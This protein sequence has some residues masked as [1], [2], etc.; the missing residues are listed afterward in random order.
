LRREHTTPFRKLWT[1]VSG[2]CVLET[3]VKFPGQ[4]SDVVE[5][6]QQL[7]LQSDVIW[8]G[9]LAS[10]QYANGVDTPVVLDGV[11]CV[12]RSAALR[13]SRLG[14]FWKRAAWKWIAKPL[15]VFERRMHAQATLSVLNSEV[16]AEYMV[17][18][19]LGSPVVIENGCDTE[20]FRPDPGLESVALPGSPTI[21][22]VGVF[23]YPPNRDAAEWLVEDL[24]PRLLRHHPDARLY[25]VGPIRSTGLLSCSDSIFATG[26]V[27]DVRPYYAQADVF[28][29]PLRYGTGIKNK[30]LEA[31]A[32]ECR[33]VATSAAVEGLA[34]RHDEHLLIADSE[35]AFVARIREILERGDATSMG[36][37]ARD[38]VE[39]GYGWEAQGERFEALLR[40]VVS[41]PDRCATDR[42]TARSLC[43][44]EVEGNDQ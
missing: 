28:V 13:V 5:T 4:F 6:V 21:V 11:D 29:A 42:F 31:A 18:E 44:S 24:M 37:R 22:F 40:E 27:P 41:G 30:L 34:F 7:A 15:P 35:E 19:G 14:S 39:H 10:M 43:Q 2:H 16:D 26:F 32:M 38:L 25:L 33:I 8:V 20:Y 3:K 36:R 17:E 9:D 12:S 23:E 1:R